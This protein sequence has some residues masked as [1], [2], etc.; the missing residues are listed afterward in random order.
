MAQ[1]FDDESTHGATT[2]PQGERP[3]PMLL[4]TL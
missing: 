1:V 3:T 2:M 4:I